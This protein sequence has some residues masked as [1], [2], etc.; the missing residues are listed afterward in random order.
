MTE[1]YRQSEAMLERARRSIPLGAQT[2][3]KSYTQFPYGVSPYFADRGEG[4]Y[5]WD[6]DGNRYLDMINSLAAIT[7]GYC[8]PSVDGAVR[9]QLDRGTI[10]S[11]SSELEMSVAEKIVAMV[12]CAD[13]VR[14]GKNG[15]DATS[16]A[17]RLARAFTGRSEVALCGY[18]GWHDWYIGTT[19][20]NRGVPPAVAAHSH[21]F[22]YNDLASLEAVLEAHAGEVAAVIMEPMNLFYPE[23]GFLEGVRELADRAGALLVFDETVTGFRFANGGAQAY[24][25]VTP[26]L[27]TFGKGLANGFPLSAVAGRRDV[28]QLMEEIF[29]SFTFGGETLSLAAAD[30]VLDR[31]AGEPI[32]ADLAERGARL[33]E[34]VN[35]LL[36]ESGLADRLSICGHP[37]WSFLVFSACDRYSD[38]ELKT[39]FMQECLRRGVLTFGSHNLSHAFG[40]AQLDELLTCY[41]EVFP[42]L[43]DAL[44]GDCL[45]QKLEGDVLKPL[46]KVR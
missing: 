23:P 43:R 9:A 46:F 17:I 20:R 19:T 37:A 40:E 26:D 7:L 14:F 34:Q 1:R 45:L 31:L 13:M 4:A 36:Q 21:L 30:A 11:L 38:L 41:R 3:S 42:L 15:S 6:V 25:G 12:P 10:F 27:A 29:F 18:H 28:M 32:L 22:Q 24:F 33:T 16:G 35:G 2:Y 8:D 5:L 39:L 44:D